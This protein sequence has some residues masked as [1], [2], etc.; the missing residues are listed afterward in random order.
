MGK[1]GGT[2]T[3]PKKLTPFS[4][5]KSLSRRRFLQ[6]L[7]TIVGG[8]AGVNSTLSAQHRGKGVQ[9]AS[10][11]A[12]QKKES[13]VLQ[14]R[15]MTRFG[16]QIEPQFGFTYPEVADLAKEAE[17]ADFTAL[18]ASDHLFFD[19]QSERRNCLEVWTLITALAPIT[20]R[21]RLGTLVTC[22]SYRLPSVLAKSAAS[23]DHLSNGRLEFGI[24]AGWKEMEYRAYGIPFPSIGTRLAQLEEAVRMLRLLWTKE[25]AS[26]SGT[27][28]RLDNAMCAPKPVQQPLKIWIGG[29]G[30][31]T[32]L[33]LVAEH[34]DGWNMLPG[35]P[36]PEVKRK[37]EVLQRHCDAVKRDFTTIDK[38]LFIVSCVVEREEELDKRVAEVEKALGPMGSAALHMARGAGTAGTPERVAETLRQFQDLGFDYFIAM[39]PYKQDR[40]MLQRFAETVMPHLR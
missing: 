21:L 38:S 40:E 16:I 7:G 29:G 39:F 4:A 6:G 2:E 13:P 12:A 37:L 36:L 35:V 32:L 18:W 25:R 30:E 28:Y 26:F 14:E 1:H 27:H 9:V 3:K 19:A 31:K 11:Q 10:T 15:R 22:N 5:K 8:V 17:R 33:R 34:A 24:G 20:T 23:F